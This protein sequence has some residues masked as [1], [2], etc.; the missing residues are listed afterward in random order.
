MV[1]TKKAFFYV[2]CYYSLLKHCCNLDVNQQQKIE[3]YLK[4]T[5]VHSI[6][7]KK[8]ALSLH[9]NDYCVKRA[10]CGNTSILIKTILTEVLYISEP[11]FI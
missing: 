2:T 11:R 8:V 1:K 5:N 7:N 6:D 9:D 3:I 10:C 4:T